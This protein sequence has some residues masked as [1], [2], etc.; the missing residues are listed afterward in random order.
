MVLDGQNPDTNDQV[1]RR[2][3]EKCPPNK[4]TL[5]VDGCSWKPFHL[6]KYLQT[7][8]SIKMKEGRRKMYDISWSIF[9]YLDKEITVGKC[10]HILE[11][12]FIEWFYT[13]I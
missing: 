2:E 5:N 7:N 8:L 1:R 12:L 4:K 3:T 9:F 6:H 13:Y 10:N 11:N